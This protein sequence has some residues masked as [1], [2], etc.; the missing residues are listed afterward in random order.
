MGRVISRFRLESQL[1]ELFLQSFDD[2]DERTRWVADAR[3]KHP[4]AFD[5]GE[6]TGAG[7]RQIESPVLAT[8]LS[9]HLTDARNLGVVDFPEKLQREMEVVPWR[10]F[11]TVTRFTQALDQAGC[12]AA[13]LRGQGYRNEGSDRFH[14][15]QIVHRKMNENQ[16][17]TFEVPPFRPHPFYRGGHLQTIVA[18][19]SARVTDLDPTRHMVEVSDG[20]RIVLHEDRPQ[21]WDPRCGSMLLVHGISGCHAAPYMMRLSRLFFHRGMRVF[22]MDMRGCG[23]GN[24]LTANLTHAGRSDDILA[25]LST[26]ADVTQSGPIA[27]I[28]VSLGAN[29]ILRAVGRVGAGIDP[30]PGW[31][32]RLDRIALV[33]PPLDLQRCS[34][35]MQRLLLRPYNYYFIRSLMSRTPPRVRQRED[36][37]QR[38]AGRRPRTLREL[39]DW[40]TAPLSGFSG[41]ADYYA[42]SSA[43]LVTRENPVRTLVLAAEDDPIVPIGC[44]VDDP[45]QW[46]ETTSLVVAPTGGHV[47]FVDR[48]RKSWMDQVMDAWFEWKES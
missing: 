20:D 9:H 36:F 10:P 25:A 13:D 47:G 41:A 39:D 44:F 33:A 3:V 35:N 21:D 7:E 11:D 22:R 38:A 2:G 45:T 46:P 5:I 31:F 8:D 42:E 23:A 19:G 28:G 4:G 30:T 29:Q 34:D 48:A 32:S 18:I 40:F 37:Q 15:Q 6:S 27:A 26:V 1:G 17:P 43:N 12:G 16:P 14:G 24:A